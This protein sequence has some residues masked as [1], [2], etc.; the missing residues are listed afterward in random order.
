MES[1]NSIDNSIIT[2]NTNWSEKWQAGSNNIDKSYV[3]ELKFFDTDKVTFLN[4]HT[5]YQKHWK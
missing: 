3:E 1:N 2:N 4:D 5:I